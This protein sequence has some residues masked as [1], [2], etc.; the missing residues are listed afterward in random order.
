MKFDREKIKKADAV[1]I[2]DG[3]FL[4]SE[5]SRAL[6][7]SAAFPLE[8]QSGLYLRC[9]IA[10]LVSLYSTIAFCAAG[11][12]ASAF[13]ATCLFIAATVS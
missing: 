2:A 11:S 6:E 10:R 7:Q 8:K 1:W 13:S 12:P 5:P 9:R 3:L 4:A